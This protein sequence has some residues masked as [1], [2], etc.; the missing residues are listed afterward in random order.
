MNTKVKVGVVVVDEDGKILLIKEKLKKNPKAL[1][2]I[3]KGTYAGGETIFETAKRECEEEASV[4]VELVN[5]LGVFVSEKNE[6]IR[7]QLNF[8]AKAHNT[9]IKIASKKD[10]Q[11][12]EENIKEAQWF[13]RDDVLKMDSAQFVSKRSFSLVQTWLS[14]SLFPLDMCKQIEM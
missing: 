13:T 14:G 11:I 4:D 2:N 8:L 6:E 12:L 1:W 7:I 3:I 10:Q 9:D 5:S